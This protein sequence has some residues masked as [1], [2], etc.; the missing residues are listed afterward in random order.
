MKKI[1]IIVLI[2]VS[3]ISLFAQKSKLLE[4]EEITFN[5]NENYSDYTLLN[6]IGL[7]ET[8]NSFLLFLNSFL[9]IGESA[10]YFDSLS[11]N[12][13]VLKLSVKDRAK[14]VVDMIDEISLE[15]G[16]SLK[17]RK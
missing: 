8:P 12:E 1:L 5:G 10:V 7:Q 11:N 17:L 16:I 9:G 14:K 2:F 15:K 13:E 3:T 6:L 4:L